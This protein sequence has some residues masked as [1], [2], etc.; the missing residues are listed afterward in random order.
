MQPDRPLARRL[1]AGVTAVPS[2][3]AL[4]VVRL[5]P[6]RAFRPLVHRMAESRLDRA[7]MPP[8]RARHARLAWLPVRVAVAVA[9]GRPVSRLQAGSRGAD[10]AGPGADMAGPGADVAGFRFRA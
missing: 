2:A 10:V 8:A 1:N 3:A 4:G 6:C 5:G 9:D 7:C